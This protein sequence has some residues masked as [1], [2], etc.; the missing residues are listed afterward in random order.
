M[1]AVL[2]T[3]SSDCLRKGA[4]T[5]TGARLG[6]R[7]VPSLAT[8]AV[9]ASLSQPTRLLRVRGELLQPNRNERP[10]AT[11]AAHWFAE[12]S[13]D[14]RGRAP[15]GFPVAHSGLTRALVYYT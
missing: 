7:A 11:R 10:Y 4:S 2:P 13:N 1:A 6:R 8:A 15:H 12:H 5:H 9:A 3:S 14:A